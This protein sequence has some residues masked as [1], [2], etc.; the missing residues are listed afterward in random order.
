MKF[1]AEISDRIRDNR[2][3]TIERIVEVRKLK[4]SC[5]FSDEFINPKNKNISRKKFPYDTKF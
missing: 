2:K 4:H 3:R 1:K 5:S